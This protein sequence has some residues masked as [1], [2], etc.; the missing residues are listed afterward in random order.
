MLPNYGTPRILIE[1]GQ[2]SFVTDSTGKKYLD[3]LAGI[4]VST[5]GH[6]HPAISKAVADQA[7]KLI[8]TSNLYAHQ[9]GLDLASKLLQLAQSDGKVL[10]AQD[11]ATANEAALKLARRHGLAVAPDGSK[12]VFVAAKNGFHGRTM[13]A[14]AVTG[15][16]SK[17]D[18]FAPFP[19]EVRFVDYG[20]S[21]QLHDAVD[22]SVCAVILEPI[23]G[24]GGINVPPPNYLETARALATAHNAVF[25]VDEV[26]SGMGRTGDWFMS[27][28]QGV[29][30]D[31]ITLAKGIAGGL[32]L[33]AMIVEPAFVNVLKPGD[34]GTTFG[35]NPL[36]CR[37]A[38]A[39]IETI[40]MQ[41]LLTHVAELSR[42]LFET[43]A[44]LDHAE[45]AGVRGKG[46]WLAIAF[47]SDCAAAVETA[48]LEAGY[49]VNAVKPN[50]IRLAPPLNVS[51]EELSTFV[52]E[53]PEILDKALA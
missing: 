52:N 30:P 9:P 1:S 36:S 12:Q 38:L 43:L 33:G 25:I 45:I 17:R 14:L 49:L 20:D 51:Q 34:H 22:D 29:R 3:L 28:A 48:C 50:A 46:L 4:A 27:L 39:V 53:L 24:E 21:T 31:I 40:E 10:F 35:G 16:P 42:W 23:Q 44:N 5:L 47:N 26:Q 11:G 41:G 8:H 15:N 13:G 18:G 7:T 32:P 2:G 6:S 19:Y 37:A